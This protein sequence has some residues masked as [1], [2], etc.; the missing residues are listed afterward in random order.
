[1]NPMAKLYRSPKTV[2]TNEDFAV[3]WEEN[4]SINLKQK[5]Y[6]YLKKG[7][8]IRL[9]RGVYVKNKDY[10]PLELATSLY[11]PSYISFETIFRQAGF[12]FQYYETIFVASSVSKIVKIDKKKITFRKLKEEILFNPQGIV[13]E[14]NYNIASPERAFLD[15]LYLSP[16]YYFDNLSLLNWE[17]CFELVNIYNNKQLVKRLS[18]YQ[19][20]YAK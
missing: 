8:L 9:T 2:L 4:N 14:G 13:K 7:S 16:N 1:M 10:D 15:M 17:K 19:K 11:V 20:D 12:V 18:A 6:R 3:I 5:I